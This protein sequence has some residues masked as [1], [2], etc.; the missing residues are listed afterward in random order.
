MLDLNGCLT[1][2]NAIPKVGLAMSPPHTTCE[3]EK[4]RHSP[5]R[6]FVSHQS[7]QPKLR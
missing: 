7:D 4:P 2:Y 6:G 3:P 1:M 5:C